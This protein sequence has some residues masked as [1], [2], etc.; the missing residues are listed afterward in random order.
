MSHRRVGVAPVRLGIRRRMVEA[1]GEGGRNPGEGC[2]WC[3]IRGGASLWTQ[4]ALLCD[5]FCAHWEGVSECVAV[6]DPSH[7]EHHH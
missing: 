6:K 1:R 4:A 3:P 2:L 5:Q 7:Y